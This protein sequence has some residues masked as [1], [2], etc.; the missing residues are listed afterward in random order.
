MTE[1]TFTCNLC[2]YTARHKHHYQKH[3]GTNKH[4]LK[5]EG[6]EPV[7]TQYHCKKCDYHTYYK[8]HYKKHLK[9]EK[10]KNKS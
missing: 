10:C 5:V 7:L 2:N 8:N 9:S 3:C 6:K 1:K 4:R